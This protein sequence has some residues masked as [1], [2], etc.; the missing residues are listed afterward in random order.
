MNQ[1]GQTLSALKWR[2]EHDLE[3]LPWLSNF[4]ELIVYWCWRFDYKWA[5]HKSPSIS[6]AP[7]AQAHSLMTTK[8]SPGHVYESVC[9]NQI[10]PPG[11]ASYQ[12]GHSP[13]CLCVWAL[14]YVPCVCA[15]VH[16][17]LT[18]SFSAHSFMLGPSSRCVDENWGGSPKSKVSS[19]WG[20]DYSIYYPSCFEMQ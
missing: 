3:I 2:A 4:L 9:L 7:Y 6:P 15:R 14:M 12:R 10:T 19:L 13:S 20:H 16:L 8:E 11:Q 5:L 17:D 18:L 1:P